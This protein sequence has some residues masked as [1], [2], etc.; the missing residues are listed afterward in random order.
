MDKLT[1]LGS[2][3]VSHPRNQTSELLQRWD[4][5]IKGKHFAKTGLGFSIEQR[6]EVSP[7]AHSHYIEMF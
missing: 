5:H 3:S 1:K 7:P 4:E 2:M 6:H